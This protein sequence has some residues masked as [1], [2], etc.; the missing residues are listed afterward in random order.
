MTK[1]TANGGAPGRLARVIARRRAGA[2]LTQAGLARAAGVTQAHVSQ[3]EAGENT[4]SL[5]VLARIAA[6][7]GAS[8]GDLVEGGMAAEARMPNTRA[9]RR[10][11]AR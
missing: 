7:L 3:V 10:G 4:P 9:G 2:G 8:V 11:G 1:M 6:A 5:A